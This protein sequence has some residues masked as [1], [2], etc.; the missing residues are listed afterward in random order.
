MASSHKRKHTV[1]DTT[2]YSSGSGS[3]SA[4]DSDAGDDDDL[5][6][7]YYESLLRDPTTGRGVYTAAMVS[8][9]VPTSPAKRVA[10]PP[11]RPDGESTWIYNFMDNDWSFPLEDQPPPSGDEADDG[12]D[13]STSVDAETLKREPAPA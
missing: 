13:S 3:G 8:A 7:Y 11:P 1:D 4:S 9:A 2:F 5:E 12:E 10:V 6:E